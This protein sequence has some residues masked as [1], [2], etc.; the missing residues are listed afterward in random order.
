MRLLFELTAH[1][2]VDVATFA[3][4]GLFMD[5]QMRMCGGWRLNSLWI[6]LS[7]T[8]SKFARTAFATTRFIRNAR[9]Q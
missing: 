5:S 7:T 8:A 1:P 2:L 9:K 6:S 3:F 4:R